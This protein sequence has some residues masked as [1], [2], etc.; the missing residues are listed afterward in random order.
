MQEQQNA[1]QMPLDVPAT[2]LPEEDFLD[3]NIDITP[4]L[5]EPVQPAWFFLQ[6]YPLL[7][8]LIMLAVGWGVGKLIQWALHTGLSKAAARTSSTVDDHLI[9]FLTAPVVQTTVILALVAATKAFGFS[10]EADW[11]LIRILFSLLLLFWGRAWFKATT[12]LIQSLSNDAGRFKMFQPRTRPLF[13][14]GIKLFLVTILIWF[15]IALWNIDGT[16]WLASPV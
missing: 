16:A 2:P 11:V 13:E 15:F 1:P 8:V 3:L 4:L 5:P 7:L 10:E 9:D 14:M 6:D 12:L